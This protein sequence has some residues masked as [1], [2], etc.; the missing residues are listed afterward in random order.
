MIRTVCIGDYQLRRGDGWVSFRVD[1]QQRVLAGGAVR[2]LGH[3]LVVAKED[4]PTIRV[5]ILARE[6]ADLG[7]YLRA[8]ADEAQA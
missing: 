4:G 3:A 5:P 2:P 1:E 8:I 6:V 7:D